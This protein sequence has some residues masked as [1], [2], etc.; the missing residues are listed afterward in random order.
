MKMA[1]SW[2]SY[3][4]EIMGIAVRHI[5]KSAYICHIELLGV[6]PF[7]SSA[8]PDNVFEGAGRPRKTV[9]RTKPAKVGFNG[10]W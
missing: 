5:K 3:Q 10:F 6:N 7:T 8:L 4:N 9:K 2:E 1:R